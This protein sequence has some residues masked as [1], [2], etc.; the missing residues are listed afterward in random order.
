MQPEPE[1]LKA[2]GKLRDSG[3]T[4][5]MDDYIGQRA[6][7]PMLPYVSLVKVDILGVGSIER[8]RE[9]AATLK[10]YNVTLLAEKVEDIETFK[11]LRD[12]GYGLFQG[13][14]FSRPETIPGRKVSALK[15]SRIQLL[16]ELGADDLD[17]STVSRVIKMDPSISYRLLKFVNMAGQSSGRNIDSVERAVTLLGQ[18]QLVQWLRAIILS[19]LNPSMKASELSFMAVGRGHLLETLAEGAGPGIPDREAMFLLGMFSVLDAILELP[20]EEL[21]KHL[22]LDEDIRAAL[23]GKESRFTLWLELARANERGDW[24]RVR[25]LTED[26]GLP[27]DLADRLSVRTLAWTQDV[28]GSARAK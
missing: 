1:V 27:Q 23:T 5:A 4:L 25:S 8:A 9:V 16:Q 20:M 26:L 19:D 13:Y 7:E 6:L 14:F 15:I 28:M 22:S 24:D 21:L 17:F 12:M 3:Y 2:L 11:A 18:R 10:R